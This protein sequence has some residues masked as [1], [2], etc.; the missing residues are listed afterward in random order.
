[1]RCFDSLRLILISYLSFRMCVLVIWNM[2]SCF[3]ENYPQMK[4]IPFSYSTYPNIYRRARRK[5]QRTGT[6]IA[7]VL[8]AF[9]EGY[10]VDEDELPEDKDPIEYASLQS[11]S[12]KQAQ[13]ETLDVTI[14]DPPSED[15]G[16]GSPHDDGIP[17]GELPLGDLG[18]PSISDAFNSVEPGDEDLETG[19][20]KLIPQVDT[21]V[22]ENPDENGLTAHHEPLS[23]TASDLD[24]TSEDDLEPDAV[25]QEPVFAATIKKEGGT[26]GKK[27]G[28]PRSG[29]AT[30]KAPVK[31]K[32]T[33]ALLS[34]RRGK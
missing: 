29:A 16:V 13:A 27:G 22:S 7:K 20:E 33:K 30:K 2:C 18:Q 6:S 21:V 1:M 32:S 12:K 14:T 15:G 17:H 34:K 3:G 5:A 28:K 23:L 31:G 9:L 10:V 24:A 26:A 25:K 4:K 8:H 19:L 11:R